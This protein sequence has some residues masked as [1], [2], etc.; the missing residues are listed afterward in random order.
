MAFSSGFSP[1]PRISYVNA[2]QTGAASE[3]EYLEIALAERRAPE[4]VRDRLDAVLPDGFAI[5]A[6]VEADRSSLAEVL[7][8]SRWSMVLPGVAE[9]VSRPAIAAFLAADRVP[10]E[11]LTKNGVRTF[12][13]RG[14]VVALEMVGPARFDLVSAIGVPLVRPD[15]VVRGLASIVP[16]MAPEEPGIFSR[17]AQGILREHTVVDPFGPGAVS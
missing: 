14:A 12:D 8:H 5:V 6:V 9:A 15:D 7:T 4:D 11:R 13:V 10:V 1:H 3:A 2:A 16:A 17:V